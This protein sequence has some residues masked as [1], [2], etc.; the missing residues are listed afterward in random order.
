MVIKGA[1]IKLTRKI[2]TGI[3]KGTRT[4][5]MI[6]T[7]TTM[8]MKMTIIKAVTKDVHIIT[9]IEI[10][11]TIKEVIIDTTIIMIEIKDLIPKKNKGNLKEEIGKESFKS[12]VE[13][14]IIVKIVKVVDLK[15]KISIIRKNKVNKVGI[16]KGTMIFQKIQKW[17]MIPSDKRRCQYLS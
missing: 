12:K 10:I 1:I 13:S 11:D 16:L 9:R 14:S 7:M 5:I 15:N 4:E 17:M 2:I 3:I 8:I 6:I